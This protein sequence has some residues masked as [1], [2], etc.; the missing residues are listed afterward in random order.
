MPHPHST[1]TQ[2]AGQLRLPIDPL[3]YAP[4]PVRARLAETHS[5]PLVAAAKGHSYRV[6][7]RKAWDYPFIELRSS[8]AYTALIVDLDGRDA[9]LAYEEHWR[10]IPEP[11]WHVLNLETGNSHLVWG[12]QRPVLRG[13]GARARPL[14][15]CRRI[16]AYYTHLLKGDPGFVGVLTRNPVAGQFHVTTWSEEP[17]TYPQ[18]ELARSIPKG[19][20]VPREYRDTGGVGR[21]CDVFRWLMQWTGKP[22]NWKRSL[23][24]ERCIAEAERLNGEVLP[25]Q[26]RV[27]MRTGEVHGIARSANK[28]ALRNRNTPESYSLWQVNQGR[29]AGIASGKSRRKGSIEEAAP[30]KAE[31]ISRRTWFYRRRRL[32]SNP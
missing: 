21:N 23:R 15:L 20:R 31:G 18:L 28:Y 17:R 12:F 7:A 24:L 29:K 11:G 6:P 22:C 19:W 30:W 1:K 27:P 25:E 8:T 13:D 10:D 14:N 16:N 9:T 3:D 2:P 32:H 4:D 5:W 26:G